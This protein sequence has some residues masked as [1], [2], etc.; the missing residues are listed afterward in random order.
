[1]G[2]VYMNV[3][4]MPALR[5]LA[6]KISATQ[7]GALQGRATRDAVALVGEVLRRYR[8]CHLRSRSAGR[9]TP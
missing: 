6:P 7:F 4:A 1:M 3:T 8:I 9:E 2:K 5:A